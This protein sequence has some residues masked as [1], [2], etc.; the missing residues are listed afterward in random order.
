MEVQGVVHLKGGVLTGKGPKRFPVVAIL[1]VTGT[2]RS[3]TNV[4]LLHRSR[5]LS[6]LVLN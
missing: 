5:L 2:T 6:I 1:G 3:E 4:Q